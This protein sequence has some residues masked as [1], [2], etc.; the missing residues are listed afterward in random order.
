M[1]GLRAGLRRVAALGVAALATAALALPT[2]AFAAELNKTASDLD[3][4]DQT[5]VQLSIGATQSTTVSDVV[6]VLDKSASTDIRQ[7]A[8]N[9]LNE[10]KTQS[11]KGNNVKVGVVNFEQGVLDSMPLTE[12]NDANFDTISEHV[13][14]HEVDSSGTNIHA[15]LVAGEQMLDADKSV[16]ADN[17]HLVLV[18]D[19]VT[20]LW[21]SDGTPYSIYSE[22]CSN[23]E[24][25]LYASHET[26]DW[27]HRGEDGDKNTADDAYYALFED[28]GSWLAENG[29]SIKQTIDTYENTYEA[30]Q[31]KAKE[32]GVTTGQ[33]RD[34]DWSVIEKFSGENSYVPEELETETASAADAA[35][36]MVATE[37][38]QI[39]SKYHAY[40][41]ADPRY[42]NNGKYEWAYNAISNLGDLKGYSAAIPSTESEYSGM[43]DAVKSSVLY[44][45]Q[46][47][48]VTDV[49][50]SDFDLTDGGNITADTFTLTVGGQ[51]LPGTVDAENPN[52]VNFDN[53]AYSVEYQVSGDTETLVWTINKP[54]ESAA[55]VTLSYNLTLVNKSTVPGDYTTKTNEE[56]TVTYKPTTGGDVTEP[57][58]VPVVAYNVPEPAPTP[59]QDALRFEPNA[60]GATGTTPSVTDDEYATVTVSENGFALDGYEFAGWNTAADGSGTAYAPGDPYTLTDADDVLYAQWKKVEEPTKP[61]EEKPADTTEQ[62]D[63]DSTLPSTGDIAGMTAGAVALA[64]A[65]A[66]GIGATLKRRR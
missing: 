42:M 16:E 21:G 43:F 19:G 33:G 13:I 48:T 12:L 22:S 54:V 5:D 63:G 49:I 25:C 1:R 30:G 31:Y 7:E 9:M 3:A 50:G 28:M 26:I 62:K 51:E 32:N 10:L 52:K 65:A 56:A 58:P 6:F 27:H 17:K 39:G 24:E 37:W 35:I 59:A 4:H 64:G 41:Y 60:E 44:E 38:Q 18:T 2:G 8:L 61:V 66:A 36:Y 11:E 20:Y 34:T 15:G 29:S 40:A 46:S 57:F 45:F 55:G 53:G 47:G 14:Y 23:G